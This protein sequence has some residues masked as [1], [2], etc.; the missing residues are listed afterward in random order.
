MSALSCFTISVIIPIYNT[1]KYL[2]KTLQSVINQ[3]I[4]FK[5]NIQIILVDDGSTDKSSDLCEKYKT[6][7]PKNIKYIKLDKNKGVSAARN[8][9]LKYAEGKYINF[10]DSDDKWSLNAYQRMIDFFEKHYDEIDM[11]SSNVWY[12]EAHEGAHTLNQYHEK[13]CIIDIDRNYKAIRSLG[14][15][16]IVKRETAE[17]FPF[18]E[19][20]KCWED[21]VF[22]N[23]VPL[24][25]KKYGMLTED[26][27]F[28]YRARTDQSSAS[29]LLY[30]RTKRY[31]LEDL[32]Y[33]FDGIYEQSKKYYGYFAPMCQYFIMNAVQIRFQEGINT[34]VLKADEVDQYKKILKNILEQ[35]EDKYIKEIA[36]AD[37]LIRKIMLAYKYGFDF[38]EDISKL[39]NDRMASC[40]ALGRVKENNRILVRWMSMIQDG[41]QLSAYFERNSYQEIA[42]Y[43]ISDIGKLLIKELEGT[44]VKI[45]YGIDRNADKF[46]GEIPIYTPT[47]VL[48]PIDVIVVTAMYFFKEIYQKLRM[49]GIKYPIVSLNEILD[50]IE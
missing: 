41:K 47:D 24:I 18:N 9:G 40:H 7:Y 49:N 25:K 44:E 4:G 38:W 36:Y 15:N 10:L 23:T 3:T 43:G 32:T 39:K 30:N 12:F 28:Y 5:E 11:V 8:T 1:E 34:S 27:R 22:I 35:I 21:S 45:Q 26:V 46:T 19:R 37:E 31:Y 16:C 48:P 6:L 42:V 50:F 13:D 14:S 17:K 29:N 33:L 20:Q 2:E